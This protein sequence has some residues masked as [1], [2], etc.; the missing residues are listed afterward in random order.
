MGPTV[1]NGLRGNHAIPQATPS[2]VLT[3]AATHFQATF[4]KVFCGPGRK[5]ASDLIHS[6]HVLARQQA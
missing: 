6:E 2:R 1:G 4:R 5:Y 3:E